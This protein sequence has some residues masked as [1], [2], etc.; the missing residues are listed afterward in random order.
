MDPTF[1]EF[2][3]VSFREPLRQGDVLESTDPSA[4]KWQRHLFVVTADCD[5]EH[6]KHQGRVTCVPF[7]TADEYLLE[8]QIPRIRDRLLSKW[9]PQLR[10]LVTQTDGPIV[11]D[12]RL[13]EWP[14]ET[15]SES[16]VS[17]LGV[18]EPSRTNAIKFFEAIRIAT[19]NYSTIGS[20]VEGMIEAQ[21]SC[22][23]SPRRDNAVE[24][25]VGPLKQCFSQPPGDA[26]FVSAI[27][28]GHE[29]GYFAYLRHIEQVSQQDISIAPDRKEVQYRRISRIEDR[30]ALALVHRFASVFASIGLP[31]PYEE[32]RDLHMQL[33][34]ERYA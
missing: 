5:F 18:T 23:N 22:P 6:D 21:V 19:S 20:A 27:A 16:I 2:R 4:Q 1:R 10:Q 26:L 14:S 32:M 29:D 11:S 8:F 15:D 9:L 13:S 30:Y 33:L 24:Q 25:A 31:Q 17:A 3:A 34:G 7:L 12:T 28:P